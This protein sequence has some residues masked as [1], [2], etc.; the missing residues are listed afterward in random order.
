MIERKVNEVKRRIICLICT[1]VISLALIIP[2][3]AGAVRITAHK[4]WYDAT[5]AYGEVTGERCTI[6]GIPHGGSLRARLVVR[7]SQQLV[8]SPGTFGGYVVDD[9]GYWWISGQVYTR[10]IPVSNS[11][12]VMKFSEH[13]C[14]MG[15]TWE[16]CSNEDSKFSSFH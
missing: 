8:L 4:D 16:N 12:Y 13:K 3:S 14:Y 5:R 1:L 7:G 11:N 15:C 10:S 2:I 6:N 9:I